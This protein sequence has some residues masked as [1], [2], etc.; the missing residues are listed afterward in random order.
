MTW[1]TNRNSNNDSG[2]ISLK[3]YNSEISVCHKELPVSLILFFF[4]L[5]LF[6]FHD[7]EYNIQLHLF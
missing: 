2:Q 5:F 7:I 1:R 6:N 3:T 4:F